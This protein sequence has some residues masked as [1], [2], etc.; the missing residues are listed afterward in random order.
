MPQLELVV[1]KRYSQGAL[2]VVELRLDVVACTAAKPIQEPR[3]IQ[4]EAY[5]D[6]PTSFVVVGAT[7]KGAYLGCACA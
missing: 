2:G 5:T 3:R 7:G 6:H 1:W 4:L